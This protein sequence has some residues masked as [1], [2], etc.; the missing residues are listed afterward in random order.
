MN[1]IATGTIDGHEARGEAALVDDGSGRLRLRLS[2]LWVAPGAPDV[3][4]Y[5]SESEH[6]RVDDSAIDL[7]RVPDHTPQLEYALP[8]GAA[9]SVA[10]TVIIYCTRFSVTFGSGSLTHSA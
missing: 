7:G 8:E 5:L 6:G 3:R 1:T 4:V 9:P 10:R 2:N